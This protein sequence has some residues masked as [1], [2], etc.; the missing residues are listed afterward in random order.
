MVTA[1]GRFAVA[2]GVMS[3]WA[4][5]QRTRRCEPKA[6]SPSD[7]GHRPLDFL[8][9]RVVAFMSLSKPGRLSRPLAPETVGTASD[10]WHVGVSL[11]FLL[12]VIRHARH[13]RPRDIRGRI[14]RISTPRLGACRVA[15]ARARMEKRRFGTMQRIKA[16]MAESGASLRPSAK[17]PASR[18]LFC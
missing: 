1:G 17:I 13:R 15:F 18:Q 14:P 8:L 4:A 11:Y 16:E 12:V 9:R 2:L 5:E 7:R 3:L 10:D 6:S